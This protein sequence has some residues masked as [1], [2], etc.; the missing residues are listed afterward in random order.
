M[1]SSR[2]VAAARARRAPE[3][4]SQS[5]LKPQMAQQR[6]PMQQPMQAPPQQI[7]LIENSPHQQHNIIQHIINQQQSQLPMVN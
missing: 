7:K 5:S 2:S 3:T 6:Q 4:P 1:S